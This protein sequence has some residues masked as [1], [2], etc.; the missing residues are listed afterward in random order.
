MNV[1]PKN[2]NFNKDFET[3]Y[4]KWLLESTGIS[5]ED[6]VWYYNAVRVSNKLNSNDLAKAIDIWFKE[7][8]PQK[9][10]FLTYF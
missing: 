7:K 4:K 1:D 3:I 8:N 6:A 2:T 9:G 5:Y 10:D